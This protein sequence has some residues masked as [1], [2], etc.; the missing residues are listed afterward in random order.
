MKTN[1]KEGKEARENFDSAMKAIF[2]APKTFSMAKHK[3]KR[4]PKASASGRASNASPKEG[5]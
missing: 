2:Q 3:K 4:K 1:Y 5:G